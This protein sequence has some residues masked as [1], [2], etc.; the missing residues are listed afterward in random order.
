M[1]PCAEIG[2]SQ[3]TIGKK[4]TSNPVIVDFQRQRVQ[5]TSFWFLIILSNHILY[6]SQNYIDTILIFAFDFGPMPPIQN[7]FTQK[8]NILGTPP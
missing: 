5:P 6:Y 2:A 3:K 1:I 8:S 4:Y 7:L